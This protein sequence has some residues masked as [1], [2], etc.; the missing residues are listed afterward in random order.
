MVRQDKRVLRVKEE[1]TDQ[2]GLGDVKGERTLQ[3]GILI[4]EF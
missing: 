4:C 3:K 2:Q 1:A